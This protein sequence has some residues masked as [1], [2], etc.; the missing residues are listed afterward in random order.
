MRLLAINLLLASSVLAS[1]K[2]LNPGD[3]G[4]LGLD[5]AVPSTPIVFCTTQVEWAGTYFSSCPGDLVMIGIQS[6]TPTS[7]SVNCG[8]VV[9]FC[10]GEDE[11]AP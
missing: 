9:V 3:E 2:Y 11:D 8:S 4:Y 5:S 1:I 6:I 7:V 10:T